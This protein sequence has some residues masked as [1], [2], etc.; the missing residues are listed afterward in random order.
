M[1]LYHATNYE[2]VKSILENGFDLKKVKIRFING[3]AI[4]FMDN[5]NRL[6]QYFGNSINKLAIL[7]V[8]FNGKIEDST[9]L[10]NIS[11]A[12]YIDYTNKL[13]RIGKIDAVRLNDGLVY[14]YNISK[15]SNIELI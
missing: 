1:K 10:K 13:I 3:Y 14:V 4:S 2:N 9:N 5:L 6:K 7:Q 8:D 12:N 15:I 11:G